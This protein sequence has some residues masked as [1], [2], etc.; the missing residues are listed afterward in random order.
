MTLSH[1]FVA[2]WRL[3]R[4]DWSLLFWGFWLALGAVASEFFLVTAV[5]FFL[6]RLNIPTL[7]R[8]VSPVP[9][10]SQPEDL[11]WQLVLGYLLPLIQVALLYW[12][13]ASMAEGALIRSVWL[14]TQGQERR[15]TLV[16][17]AREGWQLLKRFVAIDTLIFFPIFLVV[18][19]LLLVLAGGIIGVVV[20]VMQGV[21]VMWVAGLFGGVLLVCLLPLMMLLLPLWVATAVMRTLAFRETAVWGGV[22]SSVV[23]AWQLLRQ[24]WPAITILFGAG[25]GIRY[26]FSLLV[27]LPLLQLAALTN[28]EASPF[29]P[30]LVGGLSLV[31]LGIYTV[32]QTYFSIV[33]TLAYRSWH[34]QTNPIGR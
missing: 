30:V 24:Y 20:M 4:Q 12:L 19:L 17:A 31:M 16:Q 27:Q 8:P 2:A 21:A 14:A 1:L 18:F 32:T 23:R 29:Y 11:F 28:W 3:L 33:W 5:T 9:L 6:P 7:E 25:W 26:L 22:R 13:V 34:E 15:L 10:T